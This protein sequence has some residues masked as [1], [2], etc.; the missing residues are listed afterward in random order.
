[1]VV[2][3]LDETLSQSSGSQAEQMAAVSVPP[4]FVQ[5]G[6]SHP[7]QVPR[8]ATPRPRDYGALAPVAP[9]VD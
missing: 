6:N 5:A 3:L 1:M 8:T 9:L 4:I 2:I 7:F